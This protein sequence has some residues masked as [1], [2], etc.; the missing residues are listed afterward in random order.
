MKQVS[1]VALGCSLYFIEMN[2]CIP[3]GVEY[4]T[5]SKGPV[6]SSSLLFLVHFSQKTFVCFVLER[7]V[8]FKKLAYTNC[9]GMVSPK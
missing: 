9:G 1:C 5:S 3:T 2:L 6:F 7:E 4:L 8:Y